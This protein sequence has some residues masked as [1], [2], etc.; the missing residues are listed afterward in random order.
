MDEM[1][2]W[3]IVQHAHEHS[4]GDMDDKCEAITA[5]VS[6]LPRED[7]VAF[8]RLFDSMMDRSYT[9]P[10]WGAAFVIHGGCSDDTFSDFRSSL[11]SRGRQAFES[12]LADPETLADE[13]FDEDAWF[14][15]GFQYAVSDGVKAAVGSV[16]KR[17]KPFPQEPAGEE[18]SEDDV[19][20]LYPHLS[21]KFA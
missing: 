11:I 17:E 18:W 19:Y 7:A 15:E 1:Q 3:G 21:E 2:F 5:Q 13:D 4:E 9:W 16:P 10:L 8:A 6:Q 14:Y 20:E 12:A